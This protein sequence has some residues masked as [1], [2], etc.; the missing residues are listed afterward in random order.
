MFVLVRVSIAVTKKHRNQKQL[1]ERKFS[2]SLQL[3]VHTSPGEV[4]ARTQG[5]KLWAR[6]EAKVIEED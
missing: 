2:F 1:G 4:R 6:T 3:S 5:R